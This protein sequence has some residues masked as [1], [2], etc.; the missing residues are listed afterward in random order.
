MRQTNIILIKSR[1]IGRSY[2]LE[3]LYPWQRYFLILN[4]KKF[5]EKLFNI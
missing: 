1:Q 5:I 3:K 2:S 4:R